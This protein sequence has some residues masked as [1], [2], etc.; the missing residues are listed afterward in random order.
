MGLYLKPSLPLLSCLQI[1][2]DAPD[3]TYSMSTNSAG[4]VTAVFIA[5]AMPHSY[6]FS[7]VLAIVAAVIGGA[8]AILL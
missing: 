4:S 7:P 8:G 3:G 5:G 6:N 1:V 2:V